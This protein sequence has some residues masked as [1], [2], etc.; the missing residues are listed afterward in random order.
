MYLSRYDFV[1]FVFY[2]NL[3]ILYRGMLFTVF[4]TDALGIEVEWGEKKLR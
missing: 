1:V 3:V 2:L 4:V